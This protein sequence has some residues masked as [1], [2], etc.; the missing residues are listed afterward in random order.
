LSNSSLKWI[1]NDTLLKED[2]D[3]TW[4]FC[5]EAFEDESFLSWFTRLAKENCSDTRLLYQIINSED[6]RTIKNIN[7]KK[8]D[9]EF[10][11]IEIHEKKQK[12]VRKGLKPYC[13]FSSITSAVHVLNFKLRATDKLETLLTILPTP[14]YCPLCLQNDKVPFIRKKWLYPFITY[15]DD[16][17]ILLRETCPHC[18]EQIKFWRS[19]WNLPITHCYSCKKD[20]R[21]DYS[22]IS[23]VSANYQKIIN[24]IMQNCSFKG[25][26]INPRS[27]LKI[28]WKKVLEKNKTPL[29]Q[30]ESKP[31]TVEQMFR[32]LNFTL[33]SNDFIPKKIEEIKYLC[34]FEYELDMLLK[35][36]PNLEKN[37]RFLMRCHILIPYFSN[38]IYSK[39]QI[40]NS[41]SKSSVSQY[42]IY[43]WMN[44]YRKRGIKG[45]IPKKKVNRKRSK[46]FPEVV[47]DIIE[48][49]VANFEK[50]K[51]TMRECRNKIIKECVALG[52]NLSLMPSQTTIAKRI[53]KRFG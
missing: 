1:I 20:L 19:D 10:I 41:P 21:E 42:T 3:E 43:K 16:H 8:I 44:I 50:E 51:F 18:F 4:D 13:K 34:Q 27:F 12:L 9:Q 32:V 25:E 31:L 47:H 23:K 30:D 35:K 48:K 49:H 45:L 14:R 7:S 40:M 17:N 37:E 15:C 36:F 22:I 2:Y 26:P 46:W 53:H 28:L 52:Y 24:E 29:I 38:H 39:A 33:K 6:I 11:E 5:S